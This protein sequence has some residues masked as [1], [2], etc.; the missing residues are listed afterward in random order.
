MKDFLL[1]TLR[2]YYLVLVILVLALMAAGL[3]V[4]DTSIVSSIQKL[5]L[6]PYKGEVK[7]ADYPIIKANNFSEIS[8]SAAA[9]LDKNSGRIVFSKNGNVRFPPASTTKIATAIVSL[10]YFKL[11]DILTVKSNPPD[12]VGIGLE[13]GERISFENLLYAM[14]LPSAN[15]AAIAI[16]DNFP[17]GKKMFVEKMN[18]KVAELGLLNTHFEDPAGLSDGNFTTPDDLAKLASVAL[19]NEK[20]KEVVSTKSKS[21][22]NEDGSKSYTLANLNRLLGKGGVNGVKTGY[23]EEA[24]QVLVVSKDDVADGKKRTTV[25]VIMKSMDRF[26]DMEKLLGS[27]SGNITYLSTRP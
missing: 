12:G 17:G 3:F 4:Y 24:G 25:I 7:I 20:I 8:A 9:V 21:I 14:M 19:D 22:T 16:A 27:L 11:T 26:G 13:K 6:N 2:K 18:L 10:G 1:K 5:S 15:D 23:T